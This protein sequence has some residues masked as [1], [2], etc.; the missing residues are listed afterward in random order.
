MLSFHLRLRNSS[1]AGKRCHLNSIGRLAL[2]I[3]TH[4]CTDT[5]SP[6][7]AASRLS[8]RREL[9]I[10]PV[11]VKMMIGP[12]PFPAPLQRLGLFRRRNAKPSRCENH[13]T[14]RHSGSRSRV[15]L[16]TSTTEHD[17]ERIFRSSRMRQSASSRR[18]RKRTRSLQAMEQ[19]H[20]TRSVS[21]ISGN[22]VLCGSPDGIGATLQLDR[23]H[24]IR[25]HSRLPRLRAE[26][27]ITF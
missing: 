6:A 21:T 12:V 18:S 9:L 19:D 10:L 14:N 16:T 20:S 5:I 15:S 13:R 25:P 11:Q 8:R 2:R 3:M 27:R 1:A 7:A 17:G 4:A 24:T 22:Q 23:D 26:L